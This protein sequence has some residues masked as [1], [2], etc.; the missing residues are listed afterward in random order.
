MEEY[1]FDKYRVFY[2]SGPSEYAAKITCYNGQTRVAMIFFI[3]NSHLPDNELDDLPM[4]I[5]YRLSSFQDVIGLLE[6]EKP[7]AIY[8]FEN[9]KT[10][11]IGSREI[12]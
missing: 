6:N 10:C 8:V 4:K 7:L 12:N 2:R 1:L 11:E 5:H 3:D 9:R